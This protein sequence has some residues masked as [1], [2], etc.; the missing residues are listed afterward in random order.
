[1]TVSYKPAKTL[2]QQVQ[3]LHDTKRVQFNDIDEN[4]AKEILLRYNYVN[5]ITPFKHHFAKKDKS[6]EVVKVNGCHVYE[7][8]IDFKEYYEKYKEEREKYP[9]MIKNIIG[10][11]TIFKSILAYRTLTNNKIE[12]HDDLYNFLELKTN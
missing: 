12:D 11:E 1:M 6:N 7:H 10:F 8:D 5:V 9:M 4:E 3:Y 2:S